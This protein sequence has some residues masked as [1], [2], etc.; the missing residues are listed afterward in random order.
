MQK[1]NEAIAI[2]ERLEL[3]VAQLEGFSRRLEENMTQLYAKNELMTYEKKNMKVRFHQ[4][5]WHTAILKKVFITSYRNPTCCVF[6]VMT[7]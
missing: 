4:I 2:K 6:F 1:E 7:V 5:L 3:R